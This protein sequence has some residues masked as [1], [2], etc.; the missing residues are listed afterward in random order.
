MNIFA[1]NC[2][3]SFDSNGTWKD[4]TGSPINDKHLLSTW[5]VAHW[6]TNYIKQLK[7]LITRMT[8][9]FWGGT[10]I[11]P[12]N[13]LITY[14]GLVETLKNTIPLVGWGS[15]LPLIFLGFNGIV[16]PGSWDLTFV[17]K[18]VDAFLVGAIHPVRAVKGCKITVFLS[19]PPKWLLN[20]KVYTVQSSARIF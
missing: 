6:H 17:D 8:H 19:S 9:I 20:P 18:A 11:H 14:F 15:I 13:N 10:C 7:R 2:L 1:D 3:T 12:F 4:K 5:R 16:P